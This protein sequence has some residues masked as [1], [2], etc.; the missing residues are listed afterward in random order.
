MSHAEQL[1]DY[2][3]ACPAAPEPAGWERPHLSGYLWHGRLIDGCRYWCAAL[4]GDHEVRAVFDAHYSRYRYTD[5]RKPKL[6]VGPGEK[7]V[8]VTQDATAIFAWR[9]FRSMDG[10]QGVNCAIFRREPDCP[11]RASDLIREAMRLA[12]ERWPGQRLYTYVNPRAIRSS[13]PGC[14][15]RKAGWRRAGVTQKR[16]YLILEAYPDAE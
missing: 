2:I 6:F 11:Y 12:W 13:N 10:Q 4:D 3:R 5:G 1:R 16:R 7:M 9:L 8:L 14:C 15:Y